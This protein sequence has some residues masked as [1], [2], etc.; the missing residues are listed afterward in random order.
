[1]SISRQD[2]NRQCLDFVNRCKQINEEWTVSRF[3]QG[4]FMDIEGT[5]MGCIGDEQ[6]VLM[7]TH[8]IANDETKDIQ[9]Y[10]YNII[11]SESYEVPVMYFCSSNQGELS[12]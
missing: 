3:H 12:L 1:M 7:K 6:L 4:K 9:T 8:I 11:Y 5:T 10:E 2:F